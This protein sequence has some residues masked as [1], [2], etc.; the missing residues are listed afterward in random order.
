[1]IES[2]QFPDKVPFIEQTYTTA[3]AY[4][5]QEVSFTANVDVRKTYGA[6]VNEESV[7]YNFRIYLRKEAKQEITITTDPAGP[8][9]LGSE[10]GKVEFTVTCSAEDYSVT[11]SEGSSWITRN[12]EATK[13]DENFYSFDIAE[14]TTNNQRNGTINVTSEDKN[15]LLEVRQEG[16]KSEEQQGDE[17]G[18]ENQP[19]AP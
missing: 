18:K 13:P 3:Q 2:D 9:N 7:D 16:Q 8:F 11:I 1:M 17:G 12:D 19:T 14:N 4:L 6:P 10:A 5:A 15:V